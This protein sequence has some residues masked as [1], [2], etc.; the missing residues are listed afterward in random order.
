M[1]VTNVLRDVVVPA[2]SLATAL[3]CAFM[4]YKLFA[5]G[6]IGAGASTLLLTAMVSIFVAHD[7]KRL[8]FKA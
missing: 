8:F 7:V 5:L 2:A 1:S 3:G 6:Q 4:T